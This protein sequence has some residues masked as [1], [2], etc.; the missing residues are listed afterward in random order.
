MTESDSTKSRS[1]GTSR[2]ATG[3]PKSRGFCGRGGGR[4]FFFFLFFFFFFL[5]DGFNGINPPCVCHPIRFLPSLYH[6][7]KDGGLLPGVKSWR[8]VS[9]LSACLPTI[10]H[11]WHMLEIQ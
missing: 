5:V 1:G 3:V 11:H 2:V 4:F 6:M 10:L 8:V 9:S 7:G